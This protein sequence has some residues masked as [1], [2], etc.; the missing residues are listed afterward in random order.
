MHA[1]D[2]GQ[3]IDTETKR[4]GVVDRSGKMFSALEQAVERHNTVEIFDED[5]HRPTGPK[6]SLENIPLQPDSDGQ[7]L[8]LSERVNKRSCSRLSR[9]DAKV[10]EGESR[11]RRRRRPRFAIFPIS[12]PLMKSADG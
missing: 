12:R 5:S 10:L 11:G 6:Y 7:L 8:A 4:I 1:A 3:R 2:R 9:S